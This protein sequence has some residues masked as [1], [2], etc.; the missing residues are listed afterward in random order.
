MVRFPAKAVCKH[1]SSIS[2]SRLPQVERKSGKL[3]D[4]A[5]R[6]IAIVNKLMANTTPS[7]HRLLM[8]LREPPYSSTHSVQD[9]S[10]SAEAEVVP[11]AGA[12]TEPCTAL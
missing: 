7:K 12:P 9:Y 3:L 8:Y 6:V 1:D 11:A 10:G 2:T 5:T 4:T